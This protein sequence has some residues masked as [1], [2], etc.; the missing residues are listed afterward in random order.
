MP[1]DAAY[2]KEYMMERYYKRRELAI[3]KLGGKCVK[4]GSTDKL[5]V[6]HIDRTVKELSFERMTMV[7]MERFLAELA[8]CQLLCDPCHGDKTLAERGF[9][10]A[11]GTH[12]TLSSYR[13]CKCDLCKGAMK[14]WR[15]N[16]QRPSRAK[17]R[18]VTQLA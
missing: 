10:K 12:G 9:K 5:E 8:K 3:E 13:Y 7:S 16:Y 4:C 6:D 15:K 14:E 1:A 18:P 17:N 11:I 2:M